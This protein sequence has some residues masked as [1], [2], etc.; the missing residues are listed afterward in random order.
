MP[1]ASAMGYLTIKYVLPPRYRLVT[2]SQYT[3]PAVLAGW[4]P[5]AHPHAGGAR[6]AGHTTSPSPSWIGRGTLERTPPA[7]L[8]SAYTFS[9]GGSPARAGGVSDCSD[10]LWP[11]HAVGA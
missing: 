11:E 4:P 2:S 6:H 9:T 8:A 1:L 3:A 5:P 7:P 10:P